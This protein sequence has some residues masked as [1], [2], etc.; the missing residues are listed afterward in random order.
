VKTTRLLCLLTLRQRQ[1][2]TCARYHRRHTLAHSLRDW[3]HS[4]RL[5]IADGLVVLAFA[6]AAGVIVWLMP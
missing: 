2:R 6:A 1:I 3:M 4:H 5:H